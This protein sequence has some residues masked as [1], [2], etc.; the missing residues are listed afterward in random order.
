MNDPNQLSEAL[1]ILVTCQA[2]QTRMLYGVL[3]VNLT[4][5]SKSYSLMLRP[6]AGQAYCQVCLRQQ[7]MH[8]GV[9]KLLFT[10]GSGQ[11]GRRSHNVLILSV[12][13]SVRLS[14]R[15]FVTCELDIF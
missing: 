2:S 3:P 5:A 13:S 12:R 7:D 14:V 9:D 15:S 11:T 4:P 10:P 1:R 8:T 6:I